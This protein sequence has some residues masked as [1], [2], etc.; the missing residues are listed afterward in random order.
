MTGKP[1]VSDLKEELKGLRAR[2]TQAEEVLRAV[3]SGKVDALMLAGE[4][5]EQIYT[6]GGADL[7]YRQLIETMNEGAATVSAGGII[8][9]ANA[10]LAKILGLPLDQLLGAVLRN[11]L[12]PADQP[13]YDAILAQTGIKPGHG[14]INLKNSAGILVPVYL[15]SSRLKNEGAE[16]VLCLVLTD[17]TEQKVQKLLRESEEKHRE[18]FEQARDSI[19]LLEPAPDGDAV[20]R[21]I[22]AAT[23]SMHGYTR[24]ELLGRSISILNPATLTKSSVKKR[25]SAALLNNTATFESQHRRKDG[26]VFDIESSTA[27]MEIGG[28]TL[29]LAITREITERKRIETELRVTNE[30]F[31]NLTEGVSLVGI[32]DGLIKYV[33]ERFEKMFGYD[34]GELTGKD[35]AIVN[36]P[37]TKTSEETKREILDISKRTGEWH[38][39]IE[40]IK[41]DGTRFWCYANVAVIDHDRFGRVVIAVHTDITERKLAAEVLREN[42]ERYR[43]LFEAARDGILLLDFETGMIT[44]ANPFMTELLGYSKDAF[45]GKHLWEVGPF[46]DIASSKNDF[47]QLKARGYIRYEDLPLE[48]KD[49]KKAPVEFVS[50]VYQAGGKKVIQCNIR[51]I[52]RR[53]QAEAYKELA[54]EILQLLNKPGDFQESVRR[55]LAAVKARTGFDAMGIRLQDGDDFPYLVQE[56]FSK[57][58]L[59]TE[60]TLLARG[61]DG[62]ICRDKDGGVSLECTCGL[63]ISGKTDPSNPLFTPGGS[64]WTN[65]SFPLLDLPPGQDPRLHPRNRCIHHNYASV[66]L[67]PIRTQDRI[68]GLI[69]L[70]DRRKGCFSLEL[71]EFFEGIAAHI[72]EALMRK[73]A[74]TAL[75]ESEARYRTLFEQATDSILLFEMPSEGEPIIREANAAALKEFGYAREELLGKPVSML[76]DDVDAVRSIAEKHHSME[77]AGNI[78]FEL[79]H[80]RKDGSVFTAEVSARELL[81][82]GKR[83]VISL[84][85]DITDIKRYRERLELVNATL[86]GLGTDYEKNITCL[87]ELACKT[88]GADAGLYNRLHGDRLKVEG[89]YKLP[90]GMTLEDKAEGHICHDVIVNESGEPFSLLRNLQ[91]SSYLKTDPNVSKYSLQTYLGYK[92]GL[93]GLVVGSLALVWGRDFQPAEEDLKLLGIIAA[94]VKTEEERRKALEKLRESEE[95][96]RLLFEQARDS[97]MLLEL[98]PEGAPVIIDAN[99]AALRIHGYSREELIGRPISFLDT[100]IPASSLREPAGSLTFETK[101][102]HKNGSV[103]DLEVS[104]EDIVAG[105]KQ[106][107]LDISRDITERK[108]TEAGIRESYEMERMLNT[109]RQRSLEPIAL[110]QKMLTQFTALFSIP[111]LAVEPKG[112]IFLLNGRTLTLAVQQGLA[113]ALLAACAK[114]PLGK[115]L[116]GKAAASGKVVALDHVDPDHEIRYAGMRPH[117]HYCAPIIAAGATLGVLNL[118]TKEGTAFTVKQKDFIQSVTAIIASDIIH[119]RVEE[120]FAQAQKMEAV[121]QLAGGLAHDLNNILTAIMGFAE[122]LRK[123][124]PA[125]DPKRA[126]VEQVMLAGDRAIALTRQLL[127]FS[128]KQVVQFRELNLDKIIPETIIMLRRTIPENI[129]FKTSLNSATSYVLAN[130]GQIGQVITNLALNARDAMPD[131]G[132]LIFET[133]EVELDAD[134][135]A[136][137]SG[138]SPGR[139]VM[140]AVSDTGSGMSPETMAHIFEPFFTTKEKGK[141]TGLGLSIVYAIVK[142]NKGSIFVYSEPGKGTTFKLYLPV[143]AGGVYEKPAENT[144]IS[145]YRG[146][147]TVLLVEDDAAVRKFIYRALSENGYTVLEASGPGEAVR[148]CELRKDISLM[149]TDMVMPKMNGYELSE[150]MAAIIPGMKVIFMSGYTDIAM[151]HQNIL[152]HGRMLLEKPLKIE[153]VLRAIRKVLD[154]KPSLNVKPAPEA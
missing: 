130:Q 103:I 89:N 75:L 137:H 126:D 113:P 31:R 129:E 21:E 37:T 93:G 23:L 88:L 62:G 100:D 128:Q 127:T 27:K 78:S 40:N 58:F 79:L 81:V 28:K 11:Y 149:L 95:R 105:G 63:V 97:I 86:T 136:N 142:K 12:P 91:S 10:S 115:C 25:V 104:L 74:E 111:W 73:Q 119:A 51:D 110:Q 59:L 15:S 145:S 92:V 20:I 123:A 139:Y 45:V 35:V 133:A 50:N 124:I 117:G 107:I 85:R 34:A 125:G 106:L 152:G 83:M 26:S 49:G 53:K 55:V 38:G 101:H 7:A 141:G 144:P 148:L 69:Q 114:V 151:K 67:V 150:V 2:L 57:D 29:I 68:V 102:R 82:G 32:G 22:N 108:K 143:T 13:G 76:N 94:V 135:A 14:E 99:A 98:P 65:D 96:H 39:D 131:G 87:V 30:I 138:V 46:K 140:L 80:K 6:L 77:G 16:A 147:E 66:A 146:T 121:G 60:N 52:S 18:L 36:A 72:G 116:C 42:E 70:N 64:C 61:T 134:Y 17:L 1:S 8:L 112:A 48:T 120:Q 5:G 109:I 84:E 54:R 9:Y 122:F 71:V 3:H 44:E 153:T 90:A 24:G 19:I 33:N 118:Y 41:K 154:E 47:L 4:H 56:G 43:R 132:K